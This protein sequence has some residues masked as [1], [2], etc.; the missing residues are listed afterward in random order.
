[1]IKDSLFAPLDEDLYLA[2]IGGG[3]ETEVYATDNQR[4][5]VKVKSGSED[6]R[7]NSLAEA[8]AEAQQLHVTAK[9][10]ARAIDPQ[11][12]VANYIIVAKS[13]IGHCQ[14]I[15]IQPYFRHAQP[16]FEVNYDDLSFAEKRRVRH[17]L[18]DLIRCS[19]R[20]FFK[21]GW[22]PDLYGR[23]STS[24]SERTR[25]KSWHM[26]PWRLWSFLIQRNLLRSHNLMLTPD[27]RVILVDYDPM[28]HGRFYQWIY[29]R[30]RLMLFLRD[31]IVLWAVLFSWDS[32]KTDVES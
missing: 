25:L 3:N 12:H 21:E 29:Y 27:S 24:K 30:V 32:G 18:L 7:T 9:Q 13:A 31:L 5:V 6:I 4:Y 22:M 26:L 2:R 8:F 10:I 28:Q 19:V 23:I 1:M 17:Q 20:V 16:L 15:V 14:P 11:H